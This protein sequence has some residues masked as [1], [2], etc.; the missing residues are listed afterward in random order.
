MYAAG[1]Y[2]AALHVQLLA[3]RL[4]KAA[5]GELGGVV[6]AH[7]RLGEQAEDAGDVDHMA[8]AA[9]FQVR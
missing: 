1:G 7:A 6:G 9:G 4:G 2:A 5:H 3:Q 8:F